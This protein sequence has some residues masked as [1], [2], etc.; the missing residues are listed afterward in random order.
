MRPIPRFLP[1]AALALTVLAAMAAAPGPAPEPIVIGAVYN[2]TGTMAS[3]DVPGKKGM[4][5]AVERLNAAG[6]LL[7]RQVALAVRDGKTDQAAAAEAV[8]LLVAR[9][10]AKVVA[11]LNDTDYALAAGPVAMMTGVPFV[12][13]GA[14][15]PTLPERFG[16][17]FFMACFGDDAQA[18][19]AAQY[20]AKTLGLK[21]AFVLA[22]TTHEF[23]RALARD[24]KRS[25]AAQGG[26]VEGE[27]GFESGGRDLASQIAAIRALPEAPDLLFVSAVPTDAGPVSL[28][29]RQA[30]LAAPIV[31]G[32]GFDTPLLSTIP[33]RHATRIF[34]ATHVALDRPEPLV[35]EF[36][37]AYKKKFGRKP[38][39]AFAALG[40]DT[41]NLIA[42]AIRRAGSTDPEAVRAALAATRGFK[43]VTGTISY[44][45]DRRV[46][47]KTVTI[48]RY[49][50]GVRSFAGEI[51]PGA[52]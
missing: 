16:P 17:L 42:E 6:G 2:L 1:A 34:F 3:I 33:A 51:L 46:P 32:D 27:A 50:G 12:T 7:G 5:L 43:G 48:I 24:F 19:A 21:R 47:E 11:G 52:Q 14:T 35:R 40:Y 49:E 23:T 38:D 41:L 31:S 29:L 37:S 4:E 45:G 15:L 44:A 20:A 36:V 10:K 8:G 13:A 18:A 26:V 39:S 22:G 30:G 28:T 25:F 9:D